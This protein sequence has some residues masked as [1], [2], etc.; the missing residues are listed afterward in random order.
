MKRLTP[1]L[2]TFLLLAIAALL[3]ADYPTGVTTCPSSGNK[4]VSSTS[5]SLYQL[6]V[7]APSGNAGTVY[8]GGSTVTTSTGFPLIAGASY[9]AAKPSPSVNPQQLY[10]ACSN[11]GD[12]ITWIGN[13]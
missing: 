1:I 9:N 12:S 5:Y 6:T 11:S 2:F 10:F 7:L 8:V 3:Q 4:Q 13:R